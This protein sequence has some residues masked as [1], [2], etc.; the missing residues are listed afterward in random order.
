MDDRALLSAYAK[1]RAAGSA[2]A[3]GTAAEGYAAALA[4]SPDNEVLAA[5]AL[6]QAM[7]AGDQA[8]ALRAARILEKKGMVAPDARLLLLGEALR[9]KDW[10]SADRHI[11]QIQKDEVFAFM[12]PVLRAWVAHGTKKGDPLAIIAAAKADPLAGGYSAEHRP[13]LL[14]AQGRKE[15]VPELLQLSEGPSGRATRLRIAGAATIAKRD[16]A[17]ATALLQGDAPPLVAARQLLESGK[18]IPGG[19][20]TAAA[21]VAELLVRIALDLHA[22]RIGQLA[23]TYARLATFL[24][25]ENSETWLVT[26]ELLAG[27]DQQQE[28]IRVLANIRPEDPFASSAA[29]ARIRL[30]VLSGNKDA[31][32]AE[33]EAATRAP[34]AGVANWSRLGDIFT[35]LKRHEDAA[36][37]YGQ[38]LDA[39]KQGGTG[40]AEWALWLL[41]GGA[42]EQA[43]KW[44]EARAALQQAYKLAPDQ[45]LVLNYLGYAQLERREN[46]EEAMSLIVKAST[47][48]PDNHAITD[49]LGWAHYLRGN[50][51][52]A[53]ELLEKAAAGEP[54]DP[55]INEH[56]GDA[57]YSAGRR[58]E[59]RY[60]WRAALLHA[61]EADASRIRAKIDAGLTPK[62][63]AP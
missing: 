20:S 1:A 45:P 30:L 2:G 39:L 40:Q 50:L 43:D 48:Q 46:I 60:A 5:R 61:E 17:A 26:S 23:L 18:A 31:A 3:A 13:L 8:L 32:L 33:A 42:L 54:A 11:A 59:A 10:R 52:S 58:F 28:A 9:T 55:A 37:A 41:R 16:R 12:T 14:L 7:A 36:R 25:P 29:D 62:L 21:G 57:Y 24:A 22:Q 38:A 51:R 63:A 47:L 34:G 6:S 4:L 44:P 15:G 56:L 19:V 27:Q 35:E 53:I 49:S